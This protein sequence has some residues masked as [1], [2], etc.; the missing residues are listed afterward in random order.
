MQPL[1]VTLTLKL[2]LLSSAGVQTCAPHPLVSE[3]LPAITVRSV[4]PKA[5]GVTPL[6]NVALSQVRSTV[7]VLPDPVRFPSRATWIAVMVASGGTAKPN[8]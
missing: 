6:E 3:A 5:V 2:V 7:R 4:V 1:Q 8:P